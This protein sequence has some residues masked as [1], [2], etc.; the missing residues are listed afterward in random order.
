M[1]SIT[2]KNEISQ[3]NEEIEVLN[4]TMGPSIIEVPGQT[5]AV[6]LRE[7][8]NEEQNEEHVV[9]PMAEPI[10]PSQIDY[11]RRKENIYYPQFDIDDSRIANMIYRELETFMKDFNEEDK[12]FIKKRR[13]A[14]KKRI[15]RQRNKASN[16]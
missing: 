5:C 7:N 11:R 15:S 6:W 8:V 1:E 3:S 16:Q 13:A 4:T 10:H 9:V 14:L 12:K 2:I